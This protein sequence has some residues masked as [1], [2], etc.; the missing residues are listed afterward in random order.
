MYI[1]VLCRLRDAFRSK[2]TEKWRTNTWLLL[3]DNA[4]GHRSVLVNDTLTNNN[5]M[6]L[7]HPS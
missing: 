2:R 3:H 4:P 5:L 7:E 6:T 1:D